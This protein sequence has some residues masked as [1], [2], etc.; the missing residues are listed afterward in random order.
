MVKVIVLNLNG[1]TTHEDLTVEEAEKLV[2]EKG[3][4]YFVVD[5]ETKNILRELEL[6]ENQAIALI[7][8]VQGG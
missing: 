8:K 2:I 4:R 7:P 1:H 3:T 5:W 6:E